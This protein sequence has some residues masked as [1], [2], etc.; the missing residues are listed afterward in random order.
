[1]SVPVVNRKLKIFFAKAGNLNDVQPD[2]CYPPC[3]TMSTTIYARE[4]AEKNTAPEKLHCSVGKRYG[5][6]DAAG[7]ESGNNVQQLPG[8]ARYS[9]E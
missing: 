1:M 5:K 6:M 7:T 8:I 3:C 9:Q 2:K 4:T